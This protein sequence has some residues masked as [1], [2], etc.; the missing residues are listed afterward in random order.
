MKTTI[1]QPILLDNQ[2]KDDG[3][4]MSA[5]LFNAIIRRWQMSNQFL[6]QYLRRSMDTIKSYRYSRLAIPQE[7]AD[8]M[9]RVHVFLA[10]AEETNDV[11]AKRINTTKEHIFKV[12][13]NNI[14]NYDSSPIKHNKRRDKI[15]DEYRKAIEN[16]ELVIKNHYYDGKSFVW[17][18]KQ[19]YVMILQCE[20]TSSNTWIVYELMYCLPK[21][22]EG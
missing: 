16:N 4:D 1:K 21:E 14:S 15:V 13:A 18:P 7:I 10:M 9:R 8:M 22:V 20:K 19:Q 5:D 11:K 3:G 17:L 6:T 2:I 12:Y